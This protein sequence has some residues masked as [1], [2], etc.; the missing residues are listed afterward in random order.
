MEFE[1]SRKRRD[2][3]C[4]LGGEKAFRARDYSRGL[5]FKFGVE[6]REP[7]DFDDQIKSCFGGNWD[8]AWAEAVSIIRSAD[9][10]D[11]DIQSR[12]FNNVYKPRRDFLAERC[13]SLG[14]EKRAA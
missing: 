10:P 6:V 11:L 14:V 13:S 2:P 7:E 5:R 3:I 4:V 8:E 1:E 9:R 12:F